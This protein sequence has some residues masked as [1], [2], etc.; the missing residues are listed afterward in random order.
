MRFSSWFLGSLSNDSNDF[1]TIFTLVKP[2]GDV[3][4]ACAGEKKR[5]GA[6]APTTLDHWKINFPRRISTP[7]VPL[8]SA[9]LLLFKPADRS[10]L[11]NFIEASLA[12]DA[13]SRAVDERP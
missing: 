4:I 5:R 6:K 11:G 9:R 1:I 10:R 12:L 8:S 2:I 3:V 7:I 13:E